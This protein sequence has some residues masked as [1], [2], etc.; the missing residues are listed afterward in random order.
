MLAT[1]L[2]LLFSQR[3]FRR[4]LAHWWYEFWRTFLRA[5][6]VHCK[7]IL[8]VFGPPKF[9]DSIKHAMLSLNTV[10]DLWWRRKSSCGWR[11]DP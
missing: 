1:E 10:V 5:F 6:L 3:Y 4:G 7:I 9:K 2:A 8:A 11:L